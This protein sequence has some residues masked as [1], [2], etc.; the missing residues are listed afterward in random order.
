MSQMVLLLSAVI[1]TAFA[2]QMLFGIPLWI[3]VILTG[4]S[5]L[6]LLALQNYGVSGFS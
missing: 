2:L 4:F 3:G 1:G 5:T 6:I